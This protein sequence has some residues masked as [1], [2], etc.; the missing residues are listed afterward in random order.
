MGRY[1][2]RR[3]LQVVPAAAGD[4][5]PRVRALP[6]R[7]QQ[8]L[9]GRA[10]P[11]PERHAW[12]TSRASKRATASTGRSARAVPVWLCNVLRGDFGSPTSPSSPVMEM[13]L[14]R[15]P[16]TLLLTGSAFLISL[17]VG[18]PLGIL[19][20]LKRNSPFDNAIRAVRRLRHLLPLLVDRLHRHHLS[21]AA[22]C[23][24][25]L[26]ARPTAS[27]R[28][29]TCSTGCTIWPLPALVVGLDGCIGYL[30]SMRSQTLET[31]RQD[32]VRTAYAKGLA[33]A[34]RDLGS[35]PAERLSARL[36]RL[37]R[38]PGRA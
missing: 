31:L 24:G 12:R 19:C 21:W 4:Q 30:R 5:R 23:A 1:V 17:V 27:G 8:P 18:V 28:R 20:A 7:A 34:R 2:F 9:S 26:R 35:R 33:V 3:V 10:G 11:Q 6:P 15:L 38:A 36:D 16:N 13:I 25:S 37:R 14:E 32:Y 22:R 29:A